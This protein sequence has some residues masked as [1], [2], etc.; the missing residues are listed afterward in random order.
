MR[1]MKFHIW[2]FFGK[3]GGRGVELEFGFEWMEFPLFIYTDVYI[4]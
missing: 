2:V 1:E 3:G 4:F